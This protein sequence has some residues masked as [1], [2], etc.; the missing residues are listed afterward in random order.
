MN[1]PGAAA[2]MRGF[3]GVVFRSTTGAS[4]FENIYLRITSR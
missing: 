2:N 1:A 4:R 3:V